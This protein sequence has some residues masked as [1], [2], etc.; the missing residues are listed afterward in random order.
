MNTLNYYLDIAKEKTGQDG[1]TAKVIGITPAGISKAR[2][3][4][5]LSSENIVRLAQLINVNPAEIHKVCDIAR[6]PGARS[7]W[8][9]W[10]AVTLLIVGLG[11]ADISIG[12]QALAAVSST[13]QIYIMRIIMWLM[14]ARIITESLSSED[15][16]NTG[17]P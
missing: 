2:K 12:N 14:L 3:R 9:K 6:D 13:D 1:I 16:K 5:T 7:I 17:I 8:E 4:G 15:T 11:I 10:G